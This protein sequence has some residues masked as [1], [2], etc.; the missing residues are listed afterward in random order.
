MRDA[1]LN[2]ELRITNYK[3]SGLIGRFF[4]SIRFMAN[5]PLRLEHWP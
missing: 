2:Y 5:V 3:E 4:R 1:M